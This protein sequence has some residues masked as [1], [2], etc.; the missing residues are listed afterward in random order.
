MPHHMSPAEHVINQFG[1]IRATARAIKYA[2]SA[3]QKWKKRRRNLPAGT[4]PASAHL[5]ILKA[6]AILHLDIYAEDLVAKP[7]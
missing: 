7:R 5:K 4:I 1:G 3:V 2:P 6:A